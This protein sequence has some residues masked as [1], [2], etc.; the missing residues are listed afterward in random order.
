VS[1]KE[2]YN[3]SAGPPGVTK[4]L[5]GIAGG[6]HLLPTDLC[7]QN[8][9]GRNAVEEAKL[10]NVCGIDQATIIGLPAIFDCGALDMATGIRAVSYV[11]TAAF[12][13]TLLCKDRTAIFANVRAAVPQIG[14]FLEAR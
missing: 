3:V 9:L 4:R 14:E 1:N 7:Q 2:A 13:E 12:E 8:A 6:G 10:D 11:S 5:V